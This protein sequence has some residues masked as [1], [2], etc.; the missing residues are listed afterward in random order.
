MKADSVVI[1][2]GGLAGL[3]CAL[4]LPGA[5]VFEAQPAPG[6]HA[7]SHA[8][9]GAHFDQGAHI[10]HSQDPEFLD[11]ILPRAPDLHQI[12]ESH[13]RSFDGGR[14][15]TYP[16]QNHLAD[17]EESERIRALTDFVSAQMASPTSA[18]E[19]YDAW[20][21]RQYGDF[22]TDRFYAVY[23]D[24]YWRTSMRNLATDWLG[25]RLLPAQVARVVAGA[26]RSG[27]EEQSVFARFRYPARGGFFG[28]FAPLV[29]DVAIACGKRAMAIDALRRRVEFADGTTAAY[30]AL[31]SS[32]PLPDLVRLLT[33]CPADVRAAAAVLRHTRLLCVNLVVE[34]PR[35]TDDH[36]FYIYDAAIPAARVS[37]PSNLAPAMLPP[38]QTAYQAEIFRRPDEP[39]D[40]DAL[41]TQT[42]AD[43]ARLL[44]VD[45]GAFRAVQAVEV[46]YAYIV[47]DH[48]RA[49]AVAHITE[50]LEARQI[51]S[52]G[53][54]GRWKYVW[55]DVAFLDGRHTG[56]RL[57]KE[58]GL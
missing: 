52:M 21:R 12:P 24:K 40:P 11:L 33:D 28:L 47:S 26:I 25:G 42:V 31:A 27:R 51:H 17:L 36:W 41:T 29:A 18:P 3:G 2:G 8:F 22:L 44:R 5:R 10:S 50:W 45:Q 6:G 23:T 49:P 39:W 32:I 38:G 14:W 37:V 55:S 57:G 48:A 1:L 19:H 34:A 54:F 7:R 56:Q 20:C 16:V 35:L 13:V 9:A 46:P 53:L 43:L 4:A 15:I 30:D 58:L